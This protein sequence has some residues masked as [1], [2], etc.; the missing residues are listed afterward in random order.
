MAAFY[1]ISATNLLATF[2]C[3]DFFFGVELDWLIWDA[4]TFV[5]GRIQFFMRPACLECVPWVCPSSFTCPVYLSRIHKR[6]S[7]FLDLEH[8]LI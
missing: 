4:L 7:V 5:L 6:L 8:A 2:L 3:D 1:V